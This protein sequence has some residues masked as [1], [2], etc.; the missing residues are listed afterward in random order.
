MESGSIIHDR[1]D[2]THI[3]HPTAPCPS[4]DSGLSRST[5][6]GDPM[7]HDFPM[8]IEDEIILPKKLVRQ[9]SQAANS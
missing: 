9:I 1:V 6:L 8:E 5:D 3:G 4:L 7:A 2:I